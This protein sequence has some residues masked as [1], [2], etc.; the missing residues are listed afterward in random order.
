L[1]LVVL[2]AVAAAIALA[3]QGSEKSRPAGET[4]Q[5]GLYSSLP[6]LWRETPGLTGLLDSEAPSH[7]AQAVIAGHGRLVAIDTLAPED[8]PL[9]LPKDAIL[10]LAQPHPLSPQENVAL[11]EWVRGGGRVLLFAD[12]MLT[13][14]SAY[15]LG[16]RRRPQDVVLL[17]P[18]LTRWG[19]SLG[20]DEM[21]T[22]GEHE[23]EL[24]G[25][26]APVNLPGRFALTPGS[27]GCS[28]EAGGLVARCRIGMGRV[29]ALA[30]AAVLEDTGAGAA[31]RRPAALDRLLTAVAEGDREG[32]G[33]NLGK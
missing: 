11:D 19:L 6:I 31:S 1:A 29:L 12:P 2:L 5:I 18:I 13:F 15:A 25:G 8:G 24:L 20:F 32:R 14:P 23:V 17:S 4:R 3:G 28:I 16:D 21:Q 33:S 7:W 10:M 30:D 26:G 9:P 27:S 22:A